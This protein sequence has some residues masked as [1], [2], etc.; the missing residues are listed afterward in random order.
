MKLELTSHSSQIEKAAMRHSFWVFHQ[1][2]LWK[3]NELPL[4]FWSWEHKQIGT[5]IPIVTKDTVTMKHHKLA[6]SKMIE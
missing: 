2:Q 4:E 5:L 3:G 6:F 1:V